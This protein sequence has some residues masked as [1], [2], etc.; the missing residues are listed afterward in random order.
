VAARDRRARVREPA[1]DGRG[2]R[3][4]ALDERAHVPLGHAEEVRRAAGRR[5]SEPAAGGVDPLH[6]DGPERGAE[7]AGDR[8]GDG[9]AAARQ[10]D[11]DLAAGRHRRREGLPRLRAVA[12]ERREPLDDADAH[13]ASSGS[14]RRRPGERATDASTAWAACART[15]AGG[16]TRS[17]LTPGSMRS[18]API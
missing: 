4:R 14:P 15:S 9:D 1:V 13:G 2:R 11:H 18:P 8:K 17:S 5:R 3:P 10:P 16:W 12:E 7:R 6:P